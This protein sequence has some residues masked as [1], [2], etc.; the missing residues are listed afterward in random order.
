MRVVISSL[1]VAAAGFSGWVRF[2]LTGVWQAG[3]PSQ[4]APMS[5]STTIPSQP[6]H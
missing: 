1:L 6:P 4:F 2:A 5:Y 3:Y